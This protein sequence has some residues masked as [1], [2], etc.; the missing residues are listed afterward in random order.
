MAKVSKYKN[1]SSLVADEDRVYRE[2]Q[3]SHI[4]KNEG[5]RFYYDFKKYSYYHS[6]PEIVQVFS[7]AVY[8]KRNSQGHNT[9]V[10]T[11]E[12]FSYFSQFLEIRGIRTPDKLNANE[13]KF[14]SQWL[15]HSPNLKYST[16]GSL[17]RKLAS[18]FRVMS[19][20]PLISNEF[21]PVKNGFPKSE[22]VKEPQL[23]FSESEFK[24][25]L[26]AV[27]SELRESSKRLEKKYERVWFG[28]TAPI[29][30]VAPFEE[31]DDVH[32]TGSKWVSEE[33]RLWWWENVAG[34]QKL[35]YDELKKLKGG[36]EFY[37]RLKPTPNRNVITKLSNF[38]E[39]I[40]A[41]K[42]Y[43]PKYLGKKCPII[44][45]SP[46]Q[47]KEYVMWYWE[48]KL[49]CIDCT[50]KDLKD[51]DRKFYSGVQWNFG[52]FDNIRKEVN[53]GYFIHGK[54]LYPYFLMLLIR[55]GLNPSTIIRLTIDCIDVDPLDPERKMINWS[56]F[57]SYSKGQT[58]PS[59]VKNDTWPVKI[60]ERVIDITERIRG[61]G[62]VELWLSNSSSKSGHSVAIKYP[63]IRNAAKKLTEKYVVVN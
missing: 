46:W 58:I 47:K 22:Q 19:N 33:Y 41:G 63:T 39:E 60:I 2:C 7:W 57:R 37:N 6:C 20:H 4:C 21:I 32:W 11:M 15:K 42:N 49:D 34:C 30:D 17:Y 27:T 48:N 29:D 38:Y 3:F 36:R 25:I 8:K 61:E 62:Q 10:S 24:K 12:A 26:K 43:K 52:T 1:I 9:R 13:L 40:G 45:S 18:T 56:K 14:F 44:Y 31:R 55:T 35:H 16:S 50:F 51:I 54:D 59:G 23:G 5:K 53:A 28:E